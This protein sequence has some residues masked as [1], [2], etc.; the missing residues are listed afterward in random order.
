[1]LRKIKRS[2]SFSARRSV[3]DVVP[4]TPATAIPTTPTTATVA[5][6]DAREDHE[7]PSA[8]APGA[9]PKQWVEDPT[10]GDRFKLRV[11]FQLPC[12]LEG[13][14]HAFVAEHAKY[15]LMDWYGDCGDV[16]LN[17]TKWT[18]GQVLR[19][20]DEF[21][22]AGSENDASRER[23]LSLKTSLGAGTTMC[24][25]KYQRYYYYKDE[26][27]LVVRS[28]NVARGVMLV[29]TFVGYEWYVVE[30]Q[31]GGAGVRVRLLAD[32]VFSKPPYG[33]LVTQIRKGSDVAW[34]KYVKILEKKAKQV[35]GAAAAAGGGGEVKQVAVAEVQQK[36]EEK[37]AV[38][39]ETELGSDR[40]LLAGLGGAIIFLLLVLIA[41]QY[42]V[43][44]ALE[45]QRL[46]I[47]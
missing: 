26:G 42:R 1:M 40:V 43:L 28:A 14:Y 34:A 20:K 25:E 45:Q 22:F 33:F 46:V 6:E 7:P 27:V 18:S 31:A 17:A 5:T 9:L 29:D 11:D 24:T 19:A 21:D 15:S 13:F 23:Q 38:P 36:E 4:S 10:W 30:A 16:L 47:K 39:R 3:S 2:S 35:A 8:F 12:S 32:V 44:A 41:L 37:A